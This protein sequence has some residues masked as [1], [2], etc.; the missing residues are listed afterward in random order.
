MSRISCNNVLLNSLPV[1]SM[2]PECL[3]KLIVLLSC[4]PP[5]FV[6]FA[7]FFKDLFLSFLFLLLFSNL[8]T[9]WVILWSIVWATIRVTLNLP[10]SLFLSYKF[11]CFV[12]SLTELIGQ[13]IKVKVEL[14]SNSNWFIWL[15]IL[16]WLV[17]Q[18]FGF[19]WVRLLLVLILTHH[20]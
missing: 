19:S 7:I 15:L 10:F 2:N 14:I 12:H 16:Y 1:F 6:L 18:I 3:E 9:I 13:H 20:L 5:S 17:I 8:I 11:S 4:P